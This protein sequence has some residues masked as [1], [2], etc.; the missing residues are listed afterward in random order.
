MTFFHFDVMRKNYAF[1]PI[2]D[3]DHVFIFTESVLSC[4]FRLAFR[5]YLLLETLLKK[6]FSYD[7][8]IVAA[9]YRSLIYGVAFVVS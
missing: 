8:Y 1:A 6:W 7:C 3:V 9:T 2:D 4:L 5:D